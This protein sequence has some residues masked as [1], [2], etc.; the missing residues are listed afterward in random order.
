MG[1]T[2]SDVTVR[3]VSA[4]A[5]IDLRHRVL[6]AGLPRHTA[7]FVGD[8]LPTSRDFAAVD[9]AGHI[10]GCATFH[11]NQHEGEPAWQLRGMATDA[12]QCGRGI[13]RQ[14]LTTGEAAVT[15]IGPRL[16]WCKARQRAVGF[17][18]RL[19]WSICSEPFEIA[20]AGPHFQM[21]KRILPEADNGP[22]HSADRRGQ[23]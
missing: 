14:V 20:D 11:L 19:G 16:L 8:D 15:A 2:P 21:R 13:G 3:A 6:R 4:E 9:S 23:M 5:I 1:P 22:P 12:G 10:V 18:E 7:M 17:Y